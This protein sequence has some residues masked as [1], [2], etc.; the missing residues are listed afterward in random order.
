M[1]KQLWLAP[2]VLWGGLSRSYG[3]HYR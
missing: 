3:I 2:Y 1:N